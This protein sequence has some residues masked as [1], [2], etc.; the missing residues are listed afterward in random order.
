MSNGFAMDFG[1]RLSSDRFN[2]TCTVS[3]PVLAVY[4]G[5][6]W[7]IRLKRATFSGRPGHRSLVFRL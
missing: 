5:A 4:G 6:A 3:D 1:F 7:Q 2:P